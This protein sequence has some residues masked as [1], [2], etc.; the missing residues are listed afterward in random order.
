[1][2]E[3]LKKMDL[4]CAIIRAI[5]RTEEMNTAQGLQTGDHSGQKLTGISGKDL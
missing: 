4:L 3:H 5:I 1:M 2:E